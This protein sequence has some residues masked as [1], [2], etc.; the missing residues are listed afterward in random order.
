[1]T[2]P[3]PT[4]LRSTDALQTV[5]AAD[6]ERRVKAMYRDVALNPHGDY[7]FELGRD[8]AERLGYPPDVLDRIAPESIDSFAG[9][10]HH[11]ELAA[12]QSGE[13]VLDLG[14]GSGLDSLDPRAG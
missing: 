6:V 11:F 3:S 9:V 7:H 2:T 10:G 12:L 8:L 4:A 13:R 1:M 5:D 14:S